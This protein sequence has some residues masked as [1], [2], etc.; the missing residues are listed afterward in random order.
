MRPYTKCLS[1]SLA[2]WVIGKQMAAVSKNTL[3]TH[4]NGKQQINW[5]LI[6]KA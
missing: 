2:S 1:V 5:A 3:G 6:P 4:V